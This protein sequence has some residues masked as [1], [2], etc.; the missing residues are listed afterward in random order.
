MLEATLD[1][2]ISIAY[3]LMQRIDTDAKLSDVLPHFKQLAE[4]EDDEVHGFLADTFIYG[5]FD[6]PGSKPPFHTPFQQK[7]ADIYEDLCSVL[8]AKKL[9]DDDV[10]KRKFDL[11]DSNAAILTA[12]VVS[13]ELTEEPDKLIHG[14]DLRLIDLWFKGGVRHNQT[15]RALYKIKSYVYDYAGRVWRRSSDELDNIKLLGPDYRLVLDSVGALNS[16]FADQLTAALDRLKSDNPASWSLSALGCRNVVLKLGLTLWRVSGGE[17]D[18]VLLDKK[19]TIKGDAEKNKLS[20]FI[21]AHWQVADSHE[22]S[23]L[24]EAHDLVE[25]IYDK[26]SK[27][28]AS[29][30]I[31][32]SEAKGLVVDTFRLVD[33]LQQTTDLQPLTSLPPM[34]I[35]A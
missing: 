12:P 32:M 5:L 34:T 20:A 19:L 6:V 8:D 27:G 31:R 22:K 10:K 2:K 3:A 24:K 16:E 15:I 35:E 25:P 7:A 30:R 11:T 18:S 4:M 17:Y 21:D 23:L 9:S 33:L 14:Q 1:R 13:L 26:G 28:K 29:N